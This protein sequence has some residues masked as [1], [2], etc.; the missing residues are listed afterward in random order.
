LALG[1]VA[2]DSPSLYVPGVALAVIVVL[3][4]LWVGVV[5][6]HTRLE[7]EP[8]PWTIVEDEPYPLEVVVHTGGLPLP[9]GRLVHPLA[10]DA[11]P[12]PVRSPARARLEVRSLR[13]GRR[14]VDPVVLLVTDPL[15]LHTA[16]VRGGGK[17]QVLVLPR[18]EPVVVKEAAGG[19]RGNGILDGL[20]GAGATGLD[21]R[22]I[23]FEIDGLRPYRHGS[24]ASRV[25]W[26]T[27]ARRGEMM[28]HR[29]VAGGQAS[30]LVVLDSSDPDDSEAL[31]RAVRAAASLCVHLAPAGGCGLL[32]T[33]E[34]APL[35]IDPKLHAWPQAHA[36][37]AVVRGGVSP[38]PTRR[39][40]MAEAVFWVSARSAPV[41]GSRGAGIA[42]GFVVSAFPLPGTASAFTVA[43]CHG[44][45]L[46]ALRRRVRAVEASAA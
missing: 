5:A 39:A 13:R 29:L 46:A 37:L 31:D 19:G 23:D 44:Y 33:G 34:R 30:P 18:I 27:V 21:T 2:F 40:S 26:P 4:R 6:R 45:P 10:K 8:G 43:G 12:V 25:H 20:D 14:S 15:R 36:R 28:E 35:E 38:P 16:Q 3:A 24:P 17:S 1:A 9:G 32:L 42:A 11:A 7:P 22:P 41:G